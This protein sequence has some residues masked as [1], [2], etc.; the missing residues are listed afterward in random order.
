MPTRSRTK[1]IALAIL[2]A[3]SLNLGWQFNRMQRESVRG[4]K[5]YEEYGIIVCRFGPSRDEASRVYI[6]LFLM[7]AFVG[8]RLPHLKGT[9][10]TVVGFS[11]ATAVYLHWWQYYFRLAELSE[12][13]LKFVR[14]IAY[15]YNATFLDICI[16]V[17]IA[18]LVLLHIGRA[19]LLF[20]PVDWSS[21]FGATER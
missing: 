5:A 8:S 1:S 16:A 11:G 7:V 4:Q 9:L 17:S 13:E 20:R 6:E 19:L 2:V 10:L 3:A 12:S 18:L 21:A 14:H 15:L